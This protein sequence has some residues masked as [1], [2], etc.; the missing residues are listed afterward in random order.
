MSAKKNVSLIGNMGEQAPQR[1]AAPNNIDGEKTLSEFLLA[2]EKTADS[3]SNPTRF[4]RI[5]MRIDGR[6]APGSSICADGA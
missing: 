6:A 1:A 2:Y 5:R 4:Y 3:T